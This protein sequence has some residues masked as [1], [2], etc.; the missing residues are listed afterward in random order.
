MPAV[1]HAQTSFAAGELGPSVRGQFLSDV[2][3]KGLALVENWL[4]KAQGS[5]LMRAGSMRAGQEAGAFARLISFRS[6]SQLED[7][8]LA[9]TEGHLRV[10]TRAGLVSGLGPELA[11]NGN[12]NA[13]GDW[14]NGWTKI[15][16]GYVDPYSGGK[17]ALTFNPGQAAFGRVRQGVPVVA[18]HSYKLTYYANGAHIRLGST[19]GGGEYY[20]HTVV[21]PDV[22]SGRTITI[23]AA[24]AMLYID[25]EGAGDIASVAVFGT[26]SVRE[27]GAIIDLPGPWSA[28]Q[29]AGIQFVQ[30]PAKD[31]MYLVH[32]NVAPQLLTFAAP[33][34]WALAALAFTAPPADWVAGNYPSVVEWF[35]GRLLL[36]ASPASPTT[37]W[38]SKPNAPTDFSMGT[39]QPGD[40]YT[41]VVSTKGIIRWLRGHRALLLGDDVFE[42]SAVGSNYVITPADIQVREESSF[43]SAAL[44][45][46]HIGDQALFVT[47]DRQQVRALGYS[48]QDNGWISRALT[49]LAD[50][51]S[52]PGIVELAFARSPQQRIL[53][54]RSDG[55][56]VG[57]TYDRAEQVVAWWRL[58][59]TGA[60]VQSM[61]VVDGPSGSWLVLAATRAG[62]LSIEYLPLH[63]TGAVYVDAAVSGLVGAD[64]SFAGLDHLEGQK[65][66]VI[67]GGALDQTD[68]QVVA[69]GK[70]QGIDLGLAGQSIVVGLGYR[71]K[72]ATLPPEGGN[73]RGTA[74]GAKRRRVKIVV[75][76]NDSAL[77][78]VNG[79]RPPDRS[80][81]TPMDSPEPRVTGDVEVR[82][83][84]WEGDGSVTIEQDLPFRTE[85]LA[86][87]GVE[88]VN[89]L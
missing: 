87:F 71:P 43:G 9:I 6:G 64:G 82:D 77:P 31:R 81:S 34:T 84:G 5:L 40:A 14:L 72:T 30:E 75:R 17:V 33:S 3:G 27:T 58:P 32:P 59:L 46:L 24:G 63:E 66:R 22:A 37:V 20:D 88:Q 79:Q 29:L 1:S 7:F 47:R 21:Y 13:A 39:A 28:G 54:L 23:I 85:V 78:L 67:V 61:C 26:V 38:G 70:V 18:G 76:L 49:F 15:G 51:L 65:V 62:S 48:L 44:Q 4:V 60:R 80:P 74:Q 56:V 41:Q 73:P 8:V 16:A 50:H 86:V 35:Q 55:L 83:L 57:C 69:G 89:Q 36:G 12:F 52:G 68:G 25:A 45:A 53:A 2:Y 19:A 42:H 11:V 10:Y